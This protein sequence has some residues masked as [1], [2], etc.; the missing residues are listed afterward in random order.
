M[1]TRGTPRVPVPTRSGERRTPHRSLVLSCCHLRCTAELVAS[2]T[3]QGAAGGVHTPIAEA[4]D[5][6]LIQ[7][8]ADDEPRRTPSALFTRLAGQAGARD[9]ESLATAATAFTTGA[10]VP[11]MERDPHAS[12]MRP[13]RVRSYGRRAAVTAVLGRRRGNWLVAPGTTLG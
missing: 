7:V 12:R 8:A 4:P 6:G 9:P 3:S 13:K 11:R 1:P 5:G 2:P 10:P